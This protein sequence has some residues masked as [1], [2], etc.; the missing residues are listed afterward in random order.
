MNKTRTHYLEKQTGP[1]LVAFYNSLQERSDCDV[2]ACQPF[3]NG[4]DQMG[5]KLYDAFIY[6][7]ASQPI[8]EKNEI[9]LVS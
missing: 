5:A 9:K 7:K 6:Y 3:E 4:V 2:V 8:R 1:K